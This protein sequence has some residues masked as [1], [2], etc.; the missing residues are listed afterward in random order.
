MNI[1]VMQNLFHDF[2][3]SCI[4]HTS[5]LMAC[6]FISMLGIPLLQQSQQVH[7]MEDEFDVDTSTEIEVSVDDT[8]AI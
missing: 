3:N 2:K 4:E 6:H 1:F 8:E 7:S 5:H